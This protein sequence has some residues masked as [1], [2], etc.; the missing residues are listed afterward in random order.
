MLKKIIIIFL[1]LCICNPSILLA[2]STDDYTWQQISGKWS[3][4]FDNKESYLKESKGKSINFDYNPLINLNS[5]ITTNQVHLFTTLAHTFSLNAPS[6]ATTFITFFGAS[7]YRQFY[8][9]RFTGNESS[10]TAVSL[11]QSTINDTTLPKEAKNNFT[12]TTL[13]SKEVSLN[14]GQT[15]TLTIRIN[16]NTAEIII[17]E[18]P[19]LT[20]ALPNTLEAG[21]IGFASK[22]VLPIIDNLFVYNKKTLIFSDEFSQQSIRKI[23]LQGRKLTKEE[24]EEMK[25]NK[26]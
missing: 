20:C 6:S 7:D 23:V 8:G 5:I 17:D 2:Q 12:V 15:Y 16:K 24:V 22:N 13:A 10:I 21:K 25:K 4:V 9:V 26:K 18:Q 1:L 14:Y 3:C 11:I 19:I